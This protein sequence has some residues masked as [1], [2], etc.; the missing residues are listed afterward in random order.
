MQVIMNR[1][2]AV[3]SGTY[4]VGQ[5]ADVPDAIALPWL[6]SGCANAVNPDDVPE[7]PQDPAEAGAET[8]AQTDD[9]PKS[10]TESE[11]NTEGQSENEGDDTEEQEQESSEKDEYSDMTLAQL[12]EAAKA[13]DL[14]T[15]GSK[16]ELQARLRG[17]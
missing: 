16:A 13:E 11:E 2:V 12:R 15:S 1:S 4:I 9:E 17:E 10:E 5:T 8:G 6:A 3:R 7:V 14:S